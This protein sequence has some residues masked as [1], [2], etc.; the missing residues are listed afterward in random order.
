M[1][2]MVKRALGVLLII[3]VVLGLWRYLGDGASITDPAWSRNA[4]RKVASWFDE[5][6][7]LVRQRA[8]EPTRHHQSKGTR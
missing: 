2:D 3:G 8:P 6:D 4:E 7:R 1:P 5:S